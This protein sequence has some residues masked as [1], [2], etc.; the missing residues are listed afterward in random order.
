MSRQRHA[1]PA[2]DGHQQL[3]HAVD[4]GMALPHDGRTG[5]G[6]GLALVRMGEIMVDQVED[7]RRPTVQDEMTTILEAKPA[8]IV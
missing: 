6:D 5:G 8:Q 7:L 3:P 4:V 1:K 2:R